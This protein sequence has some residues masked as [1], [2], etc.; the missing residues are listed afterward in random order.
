MS[1]N[2][3]MNG[4]EKTLCTLESTCFMN[5]D[6]LV[7]VKELKSDPKMKISNFQNFQLEV[8]KNFF[9]VSLRF[10]NYT[11]EIITPPHNYYLFQAERIS[12]RRR[13][14]HMSSPA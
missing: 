3:E 14:N 7:G 9:V 2:S 5:V 6:V 4:S 11:N 13:Q 8:S 10:E 12:K 1:P